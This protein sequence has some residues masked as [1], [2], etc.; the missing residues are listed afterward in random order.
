MSMTTITHQKLIEMKLIAM[1]ALFDAHRAEPAVLS[2]DFEDR[3]A[4]LVDA[5]HAA[6]SSR[7]LERRLK[8]AQ[9]RIPSASVE[10]MRPRPSRGLDKG[11]LRQLASGEWIAQR[12]NV[13]ISG[14]TGVGKTHLACALGQKACRLDHRVLYRRLPRLLDELALAKADGTYGRLLARLARFDVLIL[15]DLGI[16][17]LRE[18]QRHDLLEVLEDRYDRSSTILAGQLPIPKWHAWIGDPT[19]ADAI[20]DRVV[21]N[22]Y[23]LTLTG[24]SGRKEKLRAQED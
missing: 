18:A 20:L 14:E 24:P 13:L 8:A 12:L 23:K 21:H 1:A 19:V 5:E 22:A 2:L 4:L 7:R 9:L 3:F 17:T 11:T 16:G 10:D 6:R 15:D